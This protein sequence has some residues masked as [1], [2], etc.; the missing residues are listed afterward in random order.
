MSRFTDI[1]I[2]K[3]YESVTVYQATKN[4]EK[5]CDLCCYRGYHLSC[6]HCHI[7]GAHET[8][9]KMLTEKKKTA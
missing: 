4:F 8:V 2:Q 3:Q 9:I 7:E 6:R 1:A 5:S